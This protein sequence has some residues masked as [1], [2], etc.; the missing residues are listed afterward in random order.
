M[1]RQKR[2]TWFTAGYN[3]IAVVFPVIV[4]A[5]RYFHGEIPL[6]GLMQTAAAFGQVQD[7]LSFI[8]NAYAQIAEWQAVVHRLVTFQAAMEQARDAGRPGVG[9]RV[10]EGAGDAVVLERL[11]VALPDGQPLLAGVTLR[12]APHDSVLIVGPSGAGKS[13]LVRVIAGVWPFGQ[14]VVRLPKAARTLFLPQTPY[15]PIGTLREVVSYPAPADGV[16]DA[17]LREA[18]AACGL[19][20]LGRLD[21]PRHWA[22]ELSPGEQQRVAFARV[23]VQR[24]DWLFLD[25]ATSAVDET[26]EA[27]LY[28]L[29]RERLPE[30]TLVSIGHR[31]ILRA[32][33]P[34]RLVVTRHD[35]G[36]ASVEEPAVA[37]VG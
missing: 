14:G 10:I 18:L 29:V 35:S 20:H 12:V 9:I 7:S 27:A 25:E 15:L 11:D 17:T 23:L 24:P 36:P 1:V 32:F 13:T 2:L 26:A 16:D 6:G 21:E 34:R 8:V 19:P 28:T 4:V 5:P 37:G 33:H 31:P 3:Q 30:L 22:L